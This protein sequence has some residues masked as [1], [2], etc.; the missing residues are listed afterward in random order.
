MRSMNMVKNNSQSQQTKEEGKTVTDLI[1]K[2]EKISNSWLEKGL[3]DRPKKNDST[4]PSSEE[5]DED[6]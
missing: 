6:K 2:S 1:E 4:V 5:K 3:P